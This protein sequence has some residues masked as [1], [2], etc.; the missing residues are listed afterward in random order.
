MSNC[1][2]DIGF[3]SRELF[4]EGLNWAGCTLIVLLGQQ[5]KFELFDFCNHLLKVNRVDMKTE[6]VNGIVSYVE[7]KNSALFH[8]LRKHVHAIYGCKND[9]FHIK[10]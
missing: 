1:N 6:K 7:I 4:G 3:V 10:K 5:R 2:A 8:S 9:N